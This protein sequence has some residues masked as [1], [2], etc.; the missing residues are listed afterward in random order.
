V[1][2]E[3]HLGVTIADWERLEFLSAARRAFVFAFVAIIILAPIRGENRRL[4][5]VSMAKGSSRDYQ[6]L[7][8]CKVLAGCGGSCP[9]KKANGAFV[10]KRGADEL[11]RCGVYAEDLLPVF[12]RSCGL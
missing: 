3:R 11:G 9:L 5:L 8:H 7:A 2:W 6:T 12:A 4:K 1:R 10:T